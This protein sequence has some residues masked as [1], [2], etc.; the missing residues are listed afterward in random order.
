LPVEFKTK[1]RAT[2]TTKSRFFGL[3]GKKNGEIEKKV[4]IRTNGTA[5][6]RIYGQSKPSL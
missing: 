4:K 2:I 1:Q 5:G 6:S 3:I